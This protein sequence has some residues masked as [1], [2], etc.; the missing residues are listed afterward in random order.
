MNNFLAITYAFMLGVCPNPSFGFSDRYEKYECPT[1]V[2]YQLGVELFNC[3]ELYT[4]EETFQVEYENLFNWYPFT[5]SYWLGVEYHKEFDKKLTVTTGVVHKC[6]H[7][8]N[9]WGVQLSDYN[10]AKTELYVGVSGKFDV[11]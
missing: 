1:H 4:G 5:Q 3:V 8:V 2:E 9:T 7:P 6:Q 10:Y 11:F